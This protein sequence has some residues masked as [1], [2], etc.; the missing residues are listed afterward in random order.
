MIVRI[1]N[2]GQYRLDDG[3]RDR[4]DELDEEVVSVCGERDE[5]RFGASYKRL[6][7]FVRDNGQR[8]ADD[9]LEQSDLLLPPADATLD[10]V[11]AEFTAEGLIP[12]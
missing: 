7:D 8:L 12:D 11:R 2:E 6:L 1:F 5:Q 9:D 3:Q 4:L 10:E